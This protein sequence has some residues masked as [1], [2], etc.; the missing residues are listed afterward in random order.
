MILMPKLA[1]RS[2]RSD[3][4]ASAAAFVDLAAV[5]LELAAVCLN[6][7][8]LLAQ[9]TL[10][11]SSSVTVLLE[12]MLVTSLVS[13]MDLTKFRE[14]VRNDS[15]ALRNAAYLFLARM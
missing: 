14:P 1:L 12:Q 8:P 11:V 6:L 4:V 3:H 2:M 15:R 9:S 10:L 5:C 13:A 7:A